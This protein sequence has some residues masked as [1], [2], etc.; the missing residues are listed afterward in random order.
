ML[1]AV[2]EQQPRADEG[3]AEG[4]QAVGGAFPADAGVIQGDEGGQG[5]E[6]DGAKGQRSAV[7]G[8]AQE[9]IGEGQPLAVDDGRR[10]LG[11]GQQQGDG[12]EQ[13]HQPADAPQPQAVHH[14]HAQR[15]ADGHRAIGGDAVPGN[16]PR[17]VLRAHQAHAP[18]DGAGADQALADAQQHPPAQQQAEARQGELGEAG[19][20][21]RQH[22]GEAAAGHAVH[23][24][25]LGAQPV[26][27][28]AGHWAGEQGGEVLG[29]DDDAR[30][31]RA[32]AHVVVY[33]AGQHGDR[34]ADAEEA[35][36]G[37]EDD[38][39]DLQR[40]G[41]RGQ[42]WRAHGRTWQRGEEDAAHDLRLGA[43]KEAG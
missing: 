5:T 41:G 42:P 37:E 6:A 10:A 15:R 19:G 28:A 38:G 23:D 24:R 35:D 4:R 9:Y 43:L 8:D 31:D 39:D 3:A 2:D 34:Q 18:A 13:G 32:I 27:Q 25:A 17:H 16:H 12:A 11:Q 40:G 7:G 22:P 20:E 1:D 30:H 36:E 14:H 21:Q 29:A 26:G 33:I